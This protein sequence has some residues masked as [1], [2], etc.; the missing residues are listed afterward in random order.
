METI[1]TY[2]LSNLDFNIVLL[3][4]ILDKV[5]MFGPGEQKDF[6]FWA[7]GKVVPKQKTS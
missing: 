4:L 1:L 3:L 6:L 2:L 7:L 5:W